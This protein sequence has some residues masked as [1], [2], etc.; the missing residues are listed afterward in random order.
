MNNQIK[1][2]ILLGQKGSNKIGI[3][4]FEQ[5]EQ[6]LDKIHDDTHQFNEVDEWDFQDE[7]EDINPW[8]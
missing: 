7:S 5:K 1:K 2:S 8:Q 6:S 3:S 4:L